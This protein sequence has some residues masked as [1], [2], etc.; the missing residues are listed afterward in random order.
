M[1]G[2]ASQHRGPAAPSD[3]EE[4][5]PRLADPSAAG[6]PARTALV[7]AAAVPASIGLALRSVVGA[8]GDT[9]RDPATRGISLIALGLILVGMIFFSVVEGWAP[10]DSLY[11]AVVTLMTVGYGDLTP[12]TALGKVG[13]IAFILSGIGIIAV[14]VSIVAGKARQ[15]S[16][17]RLSQLSQRAD[18]LDRR[19]RRAARH[20]TAQHRSDPEEPQGGR[21]N[22][23]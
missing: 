22:T 13:A 1:T 2:S 5:P 10:L 11:Y 12:H 8:V 21:G 16:Q 19:A 18:R 17:D 3:H 20:G 4:P 14:F 23:Q 7:A 6:P 15:R 9:W